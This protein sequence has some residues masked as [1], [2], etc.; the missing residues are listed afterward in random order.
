MKYLPSNCN[1]HAVQDGQ[2][3]SPPAKNLV[4]CSRHEAQH[5]FEKSFL[6][7]WFAEIFRFELA[8]RKAWVFK[9]RSCL[10]KTLDANREFSSFMHVNFLNKSQFVC[11]LHMR[12]WI[13]VPR[14][15]WRPRGWARDHHLFP[16]RDVGAGNTRKMCQWVISDLRA[17]FWGWNFESKRYRKVARIRFVFGS[18]IQDAVTKFLWMLGS[19]RGQISNTQNET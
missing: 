9:A 7:E 5:I 12:P 11:Q 6:G 10:G 15:I 18:V 3:S 19:S 4:S 8:L 16:G 14:R 1:C 2:S 17:K 13:R